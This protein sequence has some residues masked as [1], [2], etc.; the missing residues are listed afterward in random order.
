MLQMK[1]MNKRK[2]INNLCIKAIQSHQVSM[3]RNNDI[4]WSSRILPFLYNINL[5]ARTESILKNI[6]TFIKELRNMLCSEFTISIDFGLLNLLD[7]KSK[8]IFGLR[9]GGSYQLSL[10]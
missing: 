6:L 10:E 2:W 7:V 1:M 8:L 3:R 9:Y 5:W 4:E